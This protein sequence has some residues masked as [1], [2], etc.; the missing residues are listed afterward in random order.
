MSGNFNTIITIIGVIAAVIAIWSSVRRFIKKCI[1]A[2]IKFI[3]NFIAHHEL[4]SIIVLSILLLNLYLIR[5]DIMT[6]RNVSAIDQK[7][8]TISQIVS[9]VNQLIDTKI[10]IPFDNE[11]ASIYNASDDID[12][13]P[14]GG[15]IIAQGGIAGL[16][17]ETKKYIFL[18]YKLRKNHE[19]VNND[20]S[21]YY[22]TFYDRPMDYRTYR[23]LIFSIKGER[24]TTNGHKVNVGIRLT[25]DDPKDPSQTKEIVIRQLSSLEDIGIDISRN[26][27]TVIID[28]AEF[29][30]LPYTKPLPT[31][32]DPCLVNKIVF[33]VDNDIVDK[34]SNGTIY[35]KDIAFEK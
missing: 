11:K 13:F 3:A 12:H 34:Y 10:V 30:I 26:W 27:K 14:N 15:R 31:H 2:F 18:N 21:G 25:V 4:S 19:R 9:V 32:V 22:I 23:F 17:L 28:L 7:V 8:S 6:K 24:D 35:V 16:N 20:S 29:K 5:A 33:F 1:I